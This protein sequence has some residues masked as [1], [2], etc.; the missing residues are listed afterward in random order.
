MKTHRRQT[1][2]SLRGQG[3]LVINESRT[4]SQFTQASNLGPNKG[5]FQRLCA[6]LSSILVYDP[7]GGTSKGESETNW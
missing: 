3:K 7:Y 6:V 1:S 5:H 2:P 4:W